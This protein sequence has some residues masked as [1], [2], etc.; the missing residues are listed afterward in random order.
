[1]KQRII[2]AA[3]MLALALAGT[4]ARAQPATDA[5]LASLVADSLRIERDNTLIAE[6]N[7]EVFYDG[8]RLSADRIVFDRTADTIAIAGPIRLV[9]VSGAVVFADTAQLDRDLSDGILRSARVVLDQQLQLAAAEISRDGARYTRMRRVVASSCQVCADD[10]TPLWEIRASG[11]VHDQIEQQLYFENAQLRVGGIPVFYVPRLRLPDPTLERARG[12][13]VP[14]V[15]TTTDLG[16]GVIIPYFIPIGASADVTIAPY[17]ASG[18]TTL[19]GRYRQELSFGTVAGEGAFTLD[20]DILGGQ[21]RWFV[22][23]DGRFDLPY[24]FRLTFGIQAVSDPTYLLDYDYSDT[25]RLQSSIVI[26]RVRDQ[27]FTTGGLIRYS[28]LREAEIPTEDTLPEFVGQ[29]R[30][31][32]R[33]PF[34]A[35]GG[36]TWLHLDARVLTRSSNEDIVG[37]DDLRMGAAVDWRRDWIGPAGLVFDTAAGLAL[38]AYRVRDDSTFPSTPARATPF[39]AAGLRWPLERTEDGGARQILEPSVQLVYS[40]S[41]GDAVPNEDST[42]LELDEG[43]L[44]AISRYP[45][46]DA[47]EIGTRANIGVSWQRT[48]SDGLTIGVTAGRILRFSETEQFAADTG[49]GGDRSDW[50]ASI[51]LVMGERLALTSRSLVDDGFDISLSE[52]RLDWVDDWG[53][54][55]TSYLWSVPVPSEGRDTPLSEWTLAAAYEIN[56]NWQARVDWR[57]DF[58]EDRAT[59][60]GLGLQY[61]NECIGVDLSVSRRFTSSETLTPSTTYRLRLSVNGFGS[62]NDGREFRRSCTG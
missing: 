30:H 14:D 28:T 21:N 49:L 2:S 53:A 39:V 55:S 11:V 9:D 4:A 34:D 52:T 59:R 35:I 46:E 32:R 29:I 27:S 6:G 47:R 7:V 43:N 3:V 42:L 60:A 56:R 13:L 38:D 45:G 1:M 62:G 33:L 22:F 17:L 44:F 61:R 10:P 24:D 20:D 36:E 58:D 16:V 23:A 8:V 31:T 54:L 19:E 5:P 26:G 51:R 12:F 57:Y 25:D 15:R 48:S 50:L 37:R 18:T 41:F 40:D